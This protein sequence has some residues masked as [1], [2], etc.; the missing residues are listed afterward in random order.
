MKTQLSSAANPDFLATNNSSKFDSRIVFFNERLN[1]IAVV[2]ND[3][4]DSGDVFRALNTYVITVGLYESIKN[5]KLFT[6]EHTNLQEKYTK[7][8]YD[9][10]GL[11]QIFENLNFNDELNL[12]K[13]STYQENVG[14][15][16]ALLPIYI[17]AIKKNPGFSVNSDSKESQTARALLG[18]ND[19]IPGAPMS[20]CKILGNILFCLLI[21]ISLV[22]SKN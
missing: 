2:K 15:I 4:M 17:K 20:W 11:A 1:S 7:I 16:K 21:L 5:E 10:S 13:G 9:A 14:K 18:S 8:A 22:L 6:P 19:P 3:A 12:K